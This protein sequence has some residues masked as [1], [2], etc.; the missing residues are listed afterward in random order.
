[1]VIFSGEHRS[2]GTLL[3]FGFDGGGLGFEVRAQTLVI[4][5]GK[6]QGVAQMA[7]KTTPRIDFSLD[8]IVLLHH[9]LCLGWIAPK[10]RSFDFFFQLG[11]LALFGREVKDAPVTDGLTPQPTVNDSQ[12]PAC[13]LQQ[14]RLFY[15]APATVLGALSNQLLTQ[16]SLHKCIRV[17]GDQIIK[18]FAKPGE[19]DRQGELALN[20]KCHAAAR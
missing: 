9:L 6:L 16:N 19:Q 10:I 3:Q 15:S 7:G 11:K 2:K 1:M 18:L 8:G 17:K 12:G 13:F 14:Q 20:G 4:H 5:L